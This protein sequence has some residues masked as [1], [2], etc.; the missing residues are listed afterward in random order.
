M[1][2]RKRAVKHREADWTQVAY[3]TP[4]PP[5]TPELVVTQALSYCGGLHGVSFA[6]RPL[7]RSNGSESDV[8]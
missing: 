8:N 5:S 1:G 4:S 3:I 6:Y 2:E 7:A